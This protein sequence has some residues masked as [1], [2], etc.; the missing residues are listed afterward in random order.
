MQN[1][2]QRSFISAVCPSTH[3]VFL[4]KFYFSSAYEFVGTVLCN[5]LTLI[6]RRG[7]LDIFLSVIAKILCIQVKAKNGSG[8]KEMKTVI[9]SDFIDL[10]N[11]DA[12]RWYLKGHMSRELAVEVDSLLKDMSDVSF[13]NFAQTRFTLKSKLQELTKLV[14]TPTFSFLISWEPES[15]RKKMVRLVISDTDFPF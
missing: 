4:S 10:R 2:V 6:R 15:L 1:C 14:T 11:A 12:Q 7:I 9:M 8:S 5:F 3:T 13:D